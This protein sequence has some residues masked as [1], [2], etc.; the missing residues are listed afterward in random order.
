[1]QDDHHLQRIQALESDLAKCEAECDLFQSHSEAMEA[2]RDRLEAERDALLAEVKR[3][4]DTAEYA[5]LRMER[6][7]HSTRMDLEMSHDG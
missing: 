2:A 3:L 5:A 1:M 6:V 7:A 4:R